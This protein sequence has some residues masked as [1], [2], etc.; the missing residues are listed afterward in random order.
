LLEAQLIAYH[1]GDDAYAFLNFRKINNY[2]D[3]NSLFFQVLAKELHQRNEDVKEV[4]AKV[5]YLNSSLFEPSEL[6]H[7]TI[8]IS[9]LRDEKNIACFVQY[10]AQRR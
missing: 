3:L 8:F 5:P 9:N 4:F 7:N 1:K 6:E 10:R 2:D